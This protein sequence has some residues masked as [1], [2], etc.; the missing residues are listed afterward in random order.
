[1]RVASLPPTAKKR[2]ASKDLVKTRGRIVYN[3][4]ATL[5]ETFVG[6]GQKGK[7]Q[8]RR[9]KGRHS[10]VHLKEERVVSNLKKQGNYELLSLNYQTQ[11]PTRIA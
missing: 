4:Y 2:G 8:T 5:P 11:T 7:A 1:M 6:V 9:H 3:R 10:K